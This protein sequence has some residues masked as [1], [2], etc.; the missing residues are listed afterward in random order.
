MPAVTKISWNQTCDGLWKARLGMVDG[1]GYVY[2][3]LR[4]GKAFAFELVQ[5]RS[6]TGYAAKPGDRR[7]CPDAQ[8]ISS[9]SQCAACRGRDYYSDYVSGQK[10]LDTTED[11]SVYLAQCGTAVKVG[12]T[13]S[14]RLE[15][16]WVEQGADYATELYGGL[17]SDQALKIE[18]RLSEEGLP[19]RIRKEEKAVSGP[20]ILEEV[21]DEHGFSSVIMDVQEKTVY[22]QF[23]CRDVTRIGRF[24]GPV[25]SVK[26]QLVSNGRIGMILSS[27]R[28][29]QT[30]QQ[31]GLEDF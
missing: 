11:F 28:I 12:V 30:P 6:C 14:A 10:G 2:R 22:P 24:V 25:Q 3:P 7:P 17:N 16:R 13:K 29:L 9:G 19:Q 8:Q 18:E 15:Q 5:E 27:G 26:G 20:C 4:P 23:A 21:R 31:K 1:E